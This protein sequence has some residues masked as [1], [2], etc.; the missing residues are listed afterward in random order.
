M[1]EKEKKYSEQEINAQKSKIDK[2]LMRLKNLHG[3]NLTAITLQA[4][5]FLKRNS[6]AD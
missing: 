3:D 6:Y 1:K 5:E 2:E 4:V